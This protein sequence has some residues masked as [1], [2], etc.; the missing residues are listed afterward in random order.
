MAGWPATNSVRIMVGLREW[1][2]QLRHTSTSVKAA[3][4]FRFRN[5]GSI[6]AR[7][8]TKDS[9]CLLRGCASQR[10]DLS[11]VTYTRGCRSDGQ[12][13]A[14]W[15]RGGFVLGA[16]LVRGWIGGSWMASSSRARPRLP[17]PSIAATRQGEAG[18]LSNGAPGQ[19][20]ASRSRLFF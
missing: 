4:D 15:T 14:E 3:R 19:L 9:P 8:D 2:G 7:E 11:N 16:S 13:L 18:A 10:T 6:K 1:G 20:R 5:L 17:A 12:S